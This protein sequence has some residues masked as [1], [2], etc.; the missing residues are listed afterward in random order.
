MNRTNSESF[1]RSLDRDITII[2]DND[3]RYSGF[4]FPMHMCRGQGEEEEQRGGASKCET[5]EIMPR[6]YYFD[7]DGIIPPPLLQQQHANYLNHNN[8]LQF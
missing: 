5:V 8:K 6:L 7:V 4:A 3:G 1:G 2:M